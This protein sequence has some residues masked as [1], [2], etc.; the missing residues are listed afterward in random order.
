MF[1]FYEKRKLKK[2]LYS[3]TVLALLCVPVVLMIYAAYG[4]YQTKQD[5]SE[6]RE[7]LSA[8]LALLE[9]QATELEHDITMLEDPRGI[10]SELRTRY[11]VGKEGEEVIVFVEE[12]GTNTERTLAEEEKSIWQTIMQTLF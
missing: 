5:T 6:R 10:E 4:A 3:K 1:D 7:E 12:F 11:E 9:E 8:Q 2:I